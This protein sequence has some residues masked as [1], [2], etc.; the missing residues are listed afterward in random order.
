MT[1]ELPVERPPLGKILSRASTPFNLPNG[2]S[3]ARRQ[4][5]THVRQELL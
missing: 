1:A 2:P 4:E 3:V 5:P